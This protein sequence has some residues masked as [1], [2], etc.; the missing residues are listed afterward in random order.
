[1][2][3]DMSRS[4]WAALVAA[5]LLLA[6]ITGGVVA[7]ST[8]AAAAPP[9]QLVTVRA[10][11]SASTAATLTLWTRLA[12]GSYRRDYGPVTAHVGAAGVG[13][14]REGISRTPAGVFGLTQA[15]GNQA[16]NGT[17]LPY[18]RA[19]VNDW[20]DENP[21]S[22][23]YNRHV[24][25]ATSPGGASENL[26]RAG[27][28]YAHAVVIN[29]NMNPVVRGA[30][31]GFFLHVSVGTATAGCVSVPS[32]QLDTIMRWLNPAS[33]PVIS[34]GV[35]A[36]ATATVDTAN[37]AVLR[38]RAAHNPIGHVDSLGAVAGRSAVRISG[39]AI[40]PDN[41]SAQLTVGMHV[42]G[43]P[44]GHSF[45][46]VAR[47]DV[48]RIKGAG[49]RQGFAFE[50][51]VPK[52]AHRICLLAGNIGIGTGNPTLGCRVVTVT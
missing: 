24:V 5:L 32:G 20:W 30:G 38:A 46:G 37:A 36:A 15:F 9:G 51:N 42:D 10:A 13:V 29:Y 33:R 40:D 48:A 41:R 22:P 11:T 44:W 28:A 2:I 27:S 45:T 47:P 43:H 6:G 18:L 17:R 49:P 34:I 14:T 16:S 52:G 7:T 4:V 3:D 25:R 35:G 19:G 23:T 39:W 31:S 21:A 12:D 26:Y 8:T 1:M 50:L